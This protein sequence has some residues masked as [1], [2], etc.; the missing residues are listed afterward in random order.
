MHESVVPGHWVAVCMACTLK[1]L[2]KRVIGMTR[3]KKTTTVLRMIVAI[4]ALSELQSLLQMTLLFINGIN[5]FFKIQ[6]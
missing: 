2:H 6:H 5:T 4:S 1:Q 3:F